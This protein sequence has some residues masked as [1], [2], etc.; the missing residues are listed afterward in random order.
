VISC[1]RR[2]VFGHPHPDVLRALQSRDIRIWR[3][4]VNGTIVAHMTPN[5]IRVVPEIDTTR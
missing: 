5:G 1:G 2:N 4:D 3:T